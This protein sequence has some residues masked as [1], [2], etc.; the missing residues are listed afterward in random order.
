MTLFPKF[1]ER[2]NV[3][4]RRALKPGTKEYDEYYFRHP[5][6]KETDDHLRSQPYFTGNY[7]EADY[8]MCDSHEV[9]LHEL[10]HPEMVSGTPAEK[11][12]R[13]SPKR[14]AEKIKTF[15][16]RLGADLTGISELNQ[17][18]VLSHRGRFHYSAEESYGSKI[19]LGHRFA[20]S[21]GF[22]EDLDLVR[23]G[24][25]A[26]EYLAS[27]LTY[28]KSAEAAVVLAGYIRSLGYPARAHHYRNYQLLPVPVAIDGG[29]GELARC[30]FLLTKEHGNC[31]RLSTVTT[32]LPL[33]C[34]KPINIGVQDFCQRCKLCA[35]SCPSGAIPR[36][37]K[38]VLR[39]VKKWVIDPVKC[40][41]FWHKAGTD[42]GMCIGSC[43]WSEPVNLLHKASAEAASR[44]K[45]ARILLLWAYPFVYGKYV[46]LKPPEWFEE[47][48]AG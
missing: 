30:G 4:A 38:T 42:C 29:L 40:F 21:L 33:E 27:M 18:Y 6:L 13:L 7:A 3:F 1:D 43:P 17:S 10:G 28:K 31:L 11:Q 46:P 35:D 16:K 23:S 25:K 32:D 34:D 2:D 37:D 19:E 12:V 41:D 9:F 36:G 8:L 20:V 44:W 48:I 14:A 5:E 47:E 45:I 26:P 24:P 39:G 15:A 22:R